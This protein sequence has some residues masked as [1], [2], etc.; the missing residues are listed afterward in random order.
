MRILAVT[1]QYPTPG[2]PTFA[3]YNRQQFAELARL[4]ELRII[5][6][7]PWL[8]ALRETRPGRKPAVQTNADGI[9]V[10]N[11]TFYYPPRAWSHRYGAFF[12]WSIAAVAEQVLKS[13]EPDV[14][15]S[16][17]AHPDGWATARLGRQTGL[18]VVVKVLGSDVLVLA[19]GRRRDRIAEAL[20]AADAV[21]AVSQD[22]ARHV[23]R[24]GIPSLRVHVVPEGIDGER[25]SP[26]D[27]QPARERLG[28]TDDG[29][30]ILFIGNVL[31]SKGAADLVKACTILRDRGVPFHCRLVG[32]GRDAAMVAQMVRARQLEDRVILTGVRPH[33]ELTDWYRASDVV[34]LPSY[35]E[36]I[37]N[38][39]REAL[40]CGK[41]FVATHVGGIPEIADPS[42]SRLVPAGGTTD[43]AD[44]L[45]T[46][47]DSPPVVN[48]DL[49]RHINMTW[50]A[51][52]RLLAD[53]LQAVVESRRAR[54]RI[55]AADGGAG[56]IP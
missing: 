34:A 22:L 2:Q 6:P 35:S 49:V 21:V 15:L 31:V 7:V 3:P 17:W 28:L 47:L 29:R 36:G 12:E 56:V 41:P 27:R 20:G 9:K 53:Q 33:A 40:A 39:L 11:P 55:R 13:Y 1:H 38:V 51:S 19:E 25:F 48:M 43:L 30:L 54:H 42:F 46:M 8:T 4:H 32:Q 44:A 10:Y 18:P 52:A 23:E 5:R 24:L 50:E 45:E 16:S 14:L 37:P 26:G